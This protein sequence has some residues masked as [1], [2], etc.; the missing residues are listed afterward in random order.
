[1]PTRPVAGSTFTFELNLVSQANTKL[2]QTP[3]TISAG[4]FKRSINGAAFANLDN[5]PTVTPS[6]TA[7]VQI[8]LSAAETTS[9]GVGGR[10]KIDGVDAAGAEWCSVS[11]LW[12]V[13]ANDTNDVATAAA[14]AALND[15]AVADI[16]AGTVE[17]SLD[18]KETLRLALAVLVGKSTGGGTTAIAFRDTGDTKD[19]VQ[20]TVNS[21]GNRSAVVLD[22]TD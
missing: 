22:V 2:F 12:F 3:P 5:L 8:V 20:A 11:I 16:L 4:D 15:I 14:V 21:S 17:G 19:R 6:G 10:I 18:V 9:A 1:M 13:H 7:Q